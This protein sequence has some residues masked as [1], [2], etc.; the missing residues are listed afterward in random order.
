MTKR[1]HLIEKCDCDV[2]HEDVVN[3]VKSQ[4]PVE[5]SL[6]DL[7]ELFKVFGKVE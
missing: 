4:M 3:Q 7:A 2:I 5:E 6:Y 1:Y